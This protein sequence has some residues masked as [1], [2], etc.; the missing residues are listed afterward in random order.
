MKKIV[1]P[2]NFSNLSRSAALYAID[3]AA[4]T[5]GRVMVVSVIEI[6]QGTSQLMN[7]KK[8]QD[9][10]EQDT[11]QN[12]ARFMKEL[13]GYAESVSVSYTTLRG[14]SIGEQVLNF[15]RSN[16]ADLIVA[17]TKGASGLKAVVLGSNAASIINKSTIPVIAVP[18]DL[19]FS[20]FDRIV[21]ASD[22]S[23]LDNEAKAVAE[24][25][26]GFDAQIDILHVSGTDAKRRKHDELEAIL[27]RM[28]GHERLNIYV[29]ADKDITHA[30]NDY[31]HEHD[32]DLLVMF[33]HELGLFEKLFAKGHT[34]NMAFQ[35][36]IPL[37]A[38]KKP[39]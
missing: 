12:S 11:A 25:A 37:L 33:T 15:A 1:V 31:I 13:H 23:E 16:K 14:A 9:Q 38:M 21:L 36:E 29:V 2:T 8:L 6:E 18:G 10:M 5:G 28:T 7:W 39:A 4:K 32:T 3:L 27:R 35:T 24:F 20:G 22:M 19:K 26:K 17:G 30:L 34:R